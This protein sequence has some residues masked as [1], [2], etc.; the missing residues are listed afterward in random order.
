MKLTNPTRK[1]V[2]TYM[3]VG[4]PAGYGWPVRLHRWRKVFQIGAIVFLMHQNHWIDGGVM[5]LDALL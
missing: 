2:L 5:L 3:C 4:R 1:K